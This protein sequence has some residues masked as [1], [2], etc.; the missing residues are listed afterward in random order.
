MPAARWHHGAIDH[1]KPMKEATCFAG[2]ASV[3]AWTDSESAVMVFRI[4]LAR[5]ADTAKVKSVEFTMVP[6]V[7][8]DRLG[9]NA[10]VG[11][12]KRSPKLAAS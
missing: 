3:F 5:E 12:L 1:T 7:L 10:H 11:I 9:K 8:I 2:T 6:S 4:L